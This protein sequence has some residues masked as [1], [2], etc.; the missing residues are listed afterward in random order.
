MVKKM[1]NIRKKPGKEKKLRSRGEES[2]NINICVPCQAHCLGENL[3]QEGGWGLV[4]VKKPLLHADQPCCHG[5]VE[6]RR[7]E[8]QR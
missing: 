8:K 2:G 4:G 3:G 1:V 7:E 6:A 5:V